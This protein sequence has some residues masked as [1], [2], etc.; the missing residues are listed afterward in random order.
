MPAS[1]MSCELCVEAVAYQ[2]AATEELERRAFSVQATHP[3]KDKRA[4]LRVAAR[5]IKNGPLKCFHA[6]D[7]CEQQLTQLLGFGV[8][9]S[10]VWPVM[11]LKRPRVRYV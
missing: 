7:A 3:T 8:E 1:T 6:T 11:R 10:S 2:Q 5:Y 4:R 9:E